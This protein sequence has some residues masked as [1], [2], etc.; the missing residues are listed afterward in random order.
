MEGQAEEGPRATD[1]PGTL[2]RLLLFTHKEANTHPARGL[3]E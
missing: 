2:R 1:T 3:T